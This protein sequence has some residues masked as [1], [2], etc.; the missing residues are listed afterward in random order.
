MKIY[1]EIQKNDEF[2]Y[3]LGDIICNLGVVYMDKNE[4]DKAK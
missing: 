1:K 3:N 2:N 4:L